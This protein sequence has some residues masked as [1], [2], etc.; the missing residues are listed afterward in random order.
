MEK[1]SNLFNIAL[2]MKE[3]QRSFKR[4]AGNLSLDVPMESVGILLVIYYNKSELIQQEIAEAVK[5]DKSAVLRHID[6]LERKGLLQR[7]SA[8]NDRRRNVISITER[9]KQFI[10]EINGKANELFALLS[11]GLTV[12]EITTLNALLTH[13][14]NKAQN[15]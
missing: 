6:N 12:S 7:T 13:L 8:I 10:S 4:F 11:D 15:I 1:V 2:T 3:I 5:K 14:Q 9:G